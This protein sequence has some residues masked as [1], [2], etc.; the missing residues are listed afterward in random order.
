ML[1]CAKVTHFNPATNKQWAQFTNLLFN[2]SNW[3]SCCIAVFMAA[4]LTQYTLMT[5]FA[6]PQTAAS[7]TSRCQD[8]NI[9]VTYT[10]AALIQRHFSFDSFYVC[11]IIDNYKP[12]M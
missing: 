11:D 10:V 9:W 3:N 2:H 4:S 6:S 12:I 1:G 5:C 7:F 8:S